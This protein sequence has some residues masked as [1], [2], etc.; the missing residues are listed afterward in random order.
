[1][2]LAALPLRRHHARATLSAFFEQYDLLLCPTVPV[3]A[4]PNNL[5]GPETI[6]GMPA[7]P[8]AHAV[9]TPLF[10]LCDVPALSVPCGFGARGLPVGLQVVGPRFADMRVLQFG[11]E[12]AHVIDIDFSAPMLRT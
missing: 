5:I 7:G 1:V 2:Q 12:I 9:F 4:W 3:E 8:R 6:G 11:A 10:N